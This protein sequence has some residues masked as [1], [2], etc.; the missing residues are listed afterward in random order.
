MTRN[1]EFLTLNSEDGARIW[2]LTGSPSEAAAAGL[3]HTWGTWDGSYHLTPIGVLTNRLKS[4]R[5]YRIMPNRGARHVS[6]LG[7]A[8]SGTANI[9]LFY[10]PAWYFHTPGFAHPILCPESLPPASILGG[11]PL[12]SQDSA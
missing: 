12:I 9:P 4:Y 7:T 2:V 5:V 3:A 11:L 6:P 10:H 8:G 1:F